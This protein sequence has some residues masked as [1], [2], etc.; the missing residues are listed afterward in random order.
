MRPR[1]L[2][3]DV[4]CRKLEEGSV[5]IFPFK[6][7]LGFNV[8]LGKDT[9]LNYNRTFLDTAPITIDDHCKIGPDCHLVTAVRPTT[10]SGGGST[11][12]PADR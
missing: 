10:T 2:A 3:E 1:I 9:L 5:I 11:W 4:A 12:S 8:I 6:C 7:D